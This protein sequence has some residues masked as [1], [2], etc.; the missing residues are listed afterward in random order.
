MKKHLMIICALI[1]SVLCGCSTVYQS[2]Y[3]VAVEE[4]S[5]KTIA[6]DEKI[7][8]TIQQRFLQDDTVKILDISTYCYYGQVYLVG[9]YETEKER[10][11]A[12]QLASTASG[13]K[14]VIPYL[15]RKKKSDTCGITDNLEIS[16]KLKAKLIADKDIW[17]TNIDVKVVQ[18]NV[19]LLGIVGSENEI[20]KAIA[21]A[22]SVGSV[23]DVT[24]YLKATR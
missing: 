7:K 16:T 18:C 2:T 15:L 14:S 6:S 12:M 22:K 11:R 4:R 20:A 1:S 13:V 23:R 8:L 17:S 5:V 10:D 21:H 24:S 19:V 9:E 3:G